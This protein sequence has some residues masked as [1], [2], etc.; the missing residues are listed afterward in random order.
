MRWDESWTLNDI[1]KG[2]EHSRLT[3]CNAGHQTGWARR[4]EGDPIESR[5][6][7]SIREGPITRYH[8]GEVSPE[9]QLC[10]PTPKPA[11]SSEKEE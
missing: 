9:G 4:A 11:R 10:V 8:H 3:W 2:E 6:A 7:T 5:G 1:G